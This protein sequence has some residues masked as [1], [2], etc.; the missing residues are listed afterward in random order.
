M[1]NIAIDFPQNLQSHLIEIIGEAVERLGTRVKRIAAK[2]I[3][4]CDNLICNLKGSQD[5]TIAMAE[6]ADLK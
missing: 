6:I 4:K 5:L 2:E 1:K 3:I